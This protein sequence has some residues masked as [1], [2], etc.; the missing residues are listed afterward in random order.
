M[1]STYYLRY[2]GRLRLRCLGHAQRGGDHKITKRVWTEKPG[3]AR[4][5]ERPRMRWRYNVLGDFW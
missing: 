5:I 3:E 4:P 1:K 2:K